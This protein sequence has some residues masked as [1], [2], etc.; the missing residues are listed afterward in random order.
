MKAKGV[1]WS[2]SAQFSGSIKKI[3]KPRRPLREDTQSLVQTHSVNCDWQRFNELS[4][5]SYIA[6]NLDVSLNLPM[7]G[8]A[9][10]KVSALHLFTL[11][12]F[13]RLFFIHFSQGVCSYVS[14]PFLSMISCV[15]IWVTLEE[16][17][18]AS[19]SSIHMHGS[20]LMPDG[21]PL[22]YG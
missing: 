7:C 16:C 9:Y 11:P 22:W 4:E 20:L 2:G 15:C 5:H 21:F 18:M 3:A 10:K 19:W 8:M 6:L 12:T 13:I 17:S 1:S 14:V